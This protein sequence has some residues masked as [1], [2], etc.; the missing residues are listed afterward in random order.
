MRHLNGQKEQ[1][2]L[3]TRMSI[4]KTRKQEEMEHEDKK[5]IKL[6]RL[7]EHGRIEAGLAEWI[8]RVNRTQWNNDWPSTVG[9]IIYYST[10]DDRTSVRIV[11]S[12]CHFL[13]AILNGMI[14]NILREYLR[15]QLQKRRASQ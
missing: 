8:R 14:S 2:S 10:L 7:F 1:H 15:A 9:R 12:L 4:H 3:K 5:F 11:K 13:R 6:D